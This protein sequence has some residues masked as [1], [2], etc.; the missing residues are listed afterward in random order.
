MLEK[1]ETVPLQDPLMEGEK[2]R[3]KMKYFICLG[4]IILIIVTI[5][6]IVVLT[7]KD[8]DTKDDN[9]EYDDDFVRPEENWNKSYEKANEF[10][11]NLS[12]TEK[13]NLLF[14]TENMRFLDSSKTDKS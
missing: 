14:G 11:S 8:K 2:P 4:F 3:S 7:K 5:V 9:D 13:V 12:R 6:L 10:I 1:E